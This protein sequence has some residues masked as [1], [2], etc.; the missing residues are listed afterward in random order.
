MH[1]WSKICYLLILGYLIIIFE[2]RS[3]DQFY[4]TKHCAASFGKIRDCL[5][6]YSNYHTICTKFTVGKVP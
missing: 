1:M 3:Y 4:K 6:V 2:R 5:Y